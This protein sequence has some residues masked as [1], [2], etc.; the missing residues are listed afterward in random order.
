[1]HLD[2]SAGSQ[3]AADRIGDDTLEGICLQRPHDATITA[4]GQDDDN[5]T[6][7]AIRESD[8]NDSFT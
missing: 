8:L 6:E 1:M 5:Q 7:V 4:I 3:N 2:R